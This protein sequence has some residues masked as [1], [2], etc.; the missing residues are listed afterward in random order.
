[1]NELQQIIADA[2]RAIAAT[3][4]VPE[5]EQVK[6]RFLGKAGV[7]TELLKGLGRISA[8][9]RPV[10]GAAINQAKT[11]FEAMLAARKDAI[12]GAQLDS[13][14]AGEAVDVTLPGRG[15]APCGLHPITRVQEHGERIF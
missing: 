8:D 15:Q 1:M 3:S 4:S 5:L 6:A 14:L 11:D 10:R 7:L 9:E 2:S 13:R 12:L